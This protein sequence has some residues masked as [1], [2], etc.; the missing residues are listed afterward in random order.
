MKISQYHYLGG[1]LDEDIVLE[2]FEHG[3]T[4]FG[5]STRNNKRFYVIYN[6][7]KIH[8]GDP[9][10]YTFYD[11]ASHVK[12]KSY[13]ARHSKI[14]LNNGKPAYKNKNQPAYWSWNLLW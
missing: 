11:G 10:A 6:D 4:D 2:A 7:K 3:A 13:R 8:F 14:L 5:L 1:V 12:R 9:G